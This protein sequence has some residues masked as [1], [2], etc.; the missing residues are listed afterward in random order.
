MKVKSVLLP[1]YTKMELEDYPKKDKRIIVKNVSEYLMGCQKFADIQALLDRYEC[2]NPFQR[3]LKNMT[4]EYQIL[5]RRTL[6]KYLQ[7]FDVKVHEFDKYHLDRI[8]FSDKTIRRTKFPS[9]FD[10]MTSMKPTVN[11][12]AYKLS[13]NRKV[14]RM[15]HVGI[16]DMKQ[17]MFMRILSA[18]RT[19]LPSVGLMLPLKAFYAVLHKALNSSVIDKL[20]EFDTK[21]SQI[22]VPFSMLGEDFENNTDTALLS[23]GRSSPSP[24]D[25][26]I[27]KETFYMDVPFEERIGA[28]FTEAYN[29]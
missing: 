20:R 18:Y 9:E 21:K 16:S 23:K 5:Y 3:V 6:R 17:V 26:M 7:G 22:T 24:E 27:A 10:V 14:Q 29:D 13:S 11:N 19:Y 12:K 15:T 1:F 25:L 4:Q 8:D 28:D 2:H